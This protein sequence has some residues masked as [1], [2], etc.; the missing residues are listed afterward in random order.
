VEDSMGTELLSSQF[1]P[2]GPTATPR[3]PVS[4]A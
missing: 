1:R 2:D 3:A 4:W